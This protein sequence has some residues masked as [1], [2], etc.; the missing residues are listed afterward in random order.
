MGFN[1]KL[2]DFRELKK[3]QEIMEEMANLPRDN[4]PPVRQ[5]GEKGKYEEKRLQQCN[6]KEEL[7]RPE[8]STEQA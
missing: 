7:Q 8:L 5:P 3:L 4:S 6:S 2:S 1:D